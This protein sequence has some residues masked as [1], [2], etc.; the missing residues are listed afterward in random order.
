MVSIIPSTKAK[1]I[2]HYPHDAYT[3]AH[4]IG[5]DAVIINDKLH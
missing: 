1:P 4:E 2:V 3:I 5:L